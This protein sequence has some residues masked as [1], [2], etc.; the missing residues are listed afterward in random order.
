M[1][2]LPGFL[3]PPLNRVRMAIAVSGKN[4]CLS[5]TKYSVVSNS[6]TVEEIDT[7]LVL[8]RVHYSGSTESWS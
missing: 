4:F 3:S 5:A 1:R 7:K 8:S 2:P 6:E